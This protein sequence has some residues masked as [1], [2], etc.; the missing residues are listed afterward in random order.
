M[1]IR[2]VAGKFLV[3]ACLGLSA[4]APANANLVTNGGFEDVVLPTGTSFVTLGAGSPALTG[5][6][7]LGSVDHIRD[8]WVP[9]EGAQSIDLNGFGLV[10]T[11]SQT[12]ATTVGQPYEL[13]FDMAGNPDF[14][15][16]KSLLVQIDSVAQ[17]FSFDSTGQSHGAMGWITHSLVFTATDVL[18]TL[19]FQSLTF[20]FPA[21]PP[22]ERVFSFGPA[23][24]NVAV[25]AVPVPAAVWLLG[26]ALL[27]LGMIRR[28]TAA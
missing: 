6:T 10:G 25:N 14:G 2:N 27:G 17:L 16:V 28:R 23:L 20:D 8:Y 24:D 22:I 19:M 5:W 1:R 21:I 11:I 3:A 13:T 7:I 15:S 12:F 18:T 26:S 9:S 4:I